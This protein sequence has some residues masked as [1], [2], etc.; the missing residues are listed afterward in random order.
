[1]WEDDYL[2][3]LLQHLR[4]KGVGDDLGSHPTLRIV[5]VYKSLG[6]QIETEISSFCYTL[7]LDIDYRQTYNPSSTREAEAGETASFGSGWATQ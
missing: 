3:F 7:N 5:G 1:M 2:Q 6:K 4:R